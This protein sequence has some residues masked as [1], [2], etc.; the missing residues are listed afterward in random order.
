MGKRKG[1][2]GSEPGDM[3][4]GWLGTPELINEGHAPIHVCGECL[5][6]PWACHHLPSCSP[7]ACMGADPV[8]S[9]VAGNKHGF[10]ADRT[11]LP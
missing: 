3:G 4:K 6:S 10:S 8:P 7:A 9:E 1:K 11:C 2:G 5:S